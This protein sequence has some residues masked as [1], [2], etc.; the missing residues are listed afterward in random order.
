VACP[1]CGQGALYGLIADP[2]RD[3]RRLEPAAR[4]VAAVPGG[5]ELGEARRRLM[6]GLPLLVGL[7]RPAA[8]RLGR[9]LSVLGLHPRIGPAPPGT[10]PLEPSPRGPVSTYLLLAVAAAACAV[11]W[12][13]MAAP[14]REVPSPNSSTAT[15]ATRLPTPP[16]RTPEP[17]PEPTAEPASPLVVAAR[18]RWSEGRALLA[19]TAMLHGQPPRGD[20]MLV[21]RTAAGEVAWLGTAVPEDLD[22]S[23]VIRQGVPTD[24]A[25]ARFAEPVDLRGFE[26]VADFA[27]EARW[28]NWATVAEVRGLP[29]TTP[30]R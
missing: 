22:V 27:L 23:R 4:A 15:V 20:L 29:P 3:L 1:R 2:C 21:L 7:S 5:P 14:R 13:F 8:E 28:G 25:R 26:D 6:G 17:T 16:P 30:G 19:G 12:L 11:V 9:E 18:L 10:R 24:L